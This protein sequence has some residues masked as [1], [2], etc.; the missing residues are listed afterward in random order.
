MKLS[1]GNGLVNGNWTFPSFTFNGGLRLDEVNHSISVL[2]SQL[3]VLSSHYTRF[4][5]DLI[6]LD[7][8]ELLNRYESQFFV[9]LLWRAQSFHVQ[10]SRLREIEV[11][12][13]TDLEK[14]CR[15]LA[16]EIHRA[17]TNRLSK[18]RRQLRAAR[19]LR[20]ILLRFASTA[21]KFC[22]NVV[23]QRRFY[24]I[25]GSH[26]IEDSVNRKG[27]RFSQQIGGC[28]PAFQN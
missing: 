13:S 5:N 26:P 2:R 24:L 7:W 27:D 22:N 11:L 18:I 10:R 28:F 6:S 8:A 19:S 25:H 4:R 9:D 14:A 12:A 23:L 20:Q 21:H 3:G 16:V 17:F 15:L 1:L